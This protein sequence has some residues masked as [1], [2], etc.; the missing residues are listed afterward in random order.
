MNIRGIKD[1]IPTQ[2]EHR[3]GNSANFPTSNLYKIVKNRAFDLLFLLLIQIF[4]LV[5]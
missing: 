5:S 1:E 3:D 2:N 4:F